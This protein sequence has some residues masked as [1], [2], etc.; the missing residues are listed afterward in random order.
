MIDKAPLRGVP[1]DVIRTHS[2]ISGDLSECSCLSEMVLVDDVAYFWGKVK[3]SERFPLKT[4]LDICI[5][6]SNCV[7]G[8]R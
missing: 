7:D 3:E 4:A 8:G 6:T 5:D 1:K 2:L